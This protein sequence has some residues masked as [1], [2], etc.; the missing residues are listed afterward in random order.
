MGRSDAAVRRCWQESVDSGRCQ[1]HDGCGRPIATADQE[2]RLI[3]KSAV[4][5]LDSSLSTLR[6][7]IRTRV[8]TMTIYRRMRE[9]NLLSYR[10]LR[11][12]PL[13]PTHC[14]AR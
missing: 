10:P 7:A 13:T 11:P 6:R 14:R 9:Q 8:F 1:R 3:V 4:T 12:L 2:D 5:T